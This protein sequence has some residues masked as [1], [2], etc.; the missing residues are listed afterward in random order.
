MPERQCVG[1]T[2]QKEWGCTAKRWRTPDPEEMDGP[3]N[4]VN[5]AYLPVTLDGEDTYACPRQH[6]RENP[7]AYGKLWF[8]YGHYKKG[9]LPD[10]GGIVDQSNVLMQLFRVLDTANEDIDRAEEEERRKKEARR[11][12]ARRTR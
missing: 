8:L 3:E 9:H 1:C 7:A 6:L 2:R 5:P 10:R 12:R 4:W 11:G